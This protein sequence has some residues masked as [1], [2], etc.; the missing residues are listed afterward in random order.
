[1]RLAT[2]PVV[3]AGLAVLVV[4]GSCE[5][6]SEDLSQ[7]PESSGISEIDELAPVTSSPPSTPPTSV[8]LPP[9]P[10]SSRPDVDLILSRLSENNN[11]PS[12]PIGA[13][14][15][16]IRELSIFHTE[17]L[18]IASSVSLPPRETRDAD[19][20]ALLTRIDKVL[21]SVDSASLDG[22]TNEFV[23][24]FIEQVRAAMV[25]G[26]GRDLSRYE[27]VYEM[28]DEFFNFWEDYPGVE[29]YSRAFEASSSCEER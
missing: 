25:A 2:K 27:D 17:K 14:C 16:S 26:Q 3:I 19:M 5:G 6:R 7:G 1:M 11:D 18:L 8:V 13:V 15:W 20:G 22:Y 21:S 12:T 29:A 10:V 23:D 4:L 9:E 28:L 24:F